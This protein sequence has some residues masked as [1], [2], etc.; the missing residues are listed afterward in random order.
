MPNTKMDLSG[1][2]FSR[3]RFASVLS[4]GYS[5]WLCSRYAVTHP[6][7]F[8]TLTMCQACGID[9]VLYYAPVLFK[10]AGLSSNTASFL[11]SGVSG[12]INI[13]LTIF[14]QMFTD[15]WGRR[16]SMINGGVVIAGSMLTIGTLYASGATEQAAGRWAVIVLLYVFLVAFSMSW[17]VVNRIYCSEIQPMATRAAATA[18]GQCAN[19]VRCPIPP[20]NYLMLCLYVY[21]RS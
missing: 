2:C 19:W 21:Y 1:L 9:G 6:A 15:N 8:F 16:P 13:A 18:L 10:Q 14:T 17:A 11:A 20:T 7:S 3:R 12:L 4:L 5:S